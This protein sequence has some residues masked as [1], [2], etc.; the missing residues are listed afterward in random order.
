MISIPRHI[1]HS[2]ATG[3]TLLPTLLVGTPVAVYGKYAGTIAQVRKKKKYSKRYRV[4]KQW[5]RRDELTLNG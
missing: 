2:G 5:F 1:R 4:G 3:K